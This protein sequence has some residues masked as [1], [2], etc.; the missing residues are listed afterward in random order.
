M[1]DSFQHH[2][3]NERFITLMSRFYC[4]FLTPTLDISIRISKRFSL[5]CFLFT[6][7]LCVFFVILESQSKVSHLT[8]EYDNVCIYV[9]RLCETHQGQLGPVEITLLKSNFDMLFQ[10]LML[11]RC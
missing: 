4:T 3:L 2:T 6:D 5:F 8:V 9:V 7:H 10:H 11:S 1:R